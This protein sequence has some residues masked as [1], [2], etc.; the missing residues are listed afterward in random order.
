VEED[1]MYKKIFTQELKGTRRREDP[2]KD[3]KRK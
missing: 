2:G 1:R 3:A